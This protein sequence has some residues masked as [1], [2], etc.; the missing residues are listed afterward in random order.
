MQDRRNIG[1]NT[2]LKF[3]AF[4][5][6]NVRSYHFVPKVGVHLIK[7]GSR[8][9]T[10]LKDGLCKQHGAN[11]IQTSRYGDLPSAL[12]RSVCVKIS[13]YLNPLHLSAQ[14]EVR[15]QIPILP[16]RRLWIN[17]SGGYKA[18]GASVYLDMEIDRQQHQLYCCGCAIVVF[19]CSVSRW[20]CRIRGRGMAKGVFDK[21]KLAQACRRHLSLEG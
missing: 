6:E 16:P 20:R 5:S 11:R 10:Y 15:H 17:P 18:S 1:G 19:I 21:H 8:L 14:L 3:S 12:N 7:T 13:L 2:S 9:P 4:S